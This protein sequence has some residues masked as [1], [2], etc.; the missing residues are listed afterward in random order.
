MREH[1]GQ[2]CEANAADPA[3]CCIVA[4]P[5]EG[6]E[7]KRNEGKQS[8]ARPKDVEKDEARSSRAA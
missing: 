7:R 3:G 6:K 8:R 4:R 2:L 5:A 1:F